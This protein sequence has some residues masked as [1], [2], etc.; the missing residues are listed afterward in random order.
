MSNAAFDGIVW[1]AKAGGIFQFDLA[2]VL[3]GEWNHV[4]FRTYHVAWYRAFTGAADD[5]SWLYEVDSGENRNG[6][7]YYG[8]YFLGYQMPCFVD[9]AGFL[10]EE[11]LY[12]YTTPDRT[13]WGDDLG[14]WKFAALADFKVS[15]N[16]S[17]TL[18]V[19]FW[20]VRNFEGSTGDYKFYQ[21]RV[22]DRD[23]PYRIEFYRAVASVTVRL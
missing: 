2:A 23:N 21:D 19:Q 20:T 9:R 1:S 5:E 11:D 13:D 7:N 18:L 14:R 17:T 4:V 3:P 12:L 8:N 16:V 10:V 15:D 22:I 6:W